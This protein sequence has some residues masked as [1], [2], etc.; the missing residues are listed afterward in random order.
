MTDQRPVMVR[1]SKAQAVFGVHRATIYRWVAAGHIH[2][3]KRGTMSFL[4]PAEVTAFIKGMGD[5][6]G[7]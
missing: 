2:L 1:V 4:D 3:Y 7:G 5:Q 6:V